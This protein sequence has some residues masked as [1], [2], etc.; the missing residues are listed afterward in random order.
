MGLD[1][2]AVTP[3]LVLAV[4]LLALGDDA[5]RAVEALVLQ[6]VENHH[7]GAWLQLDLLHLRGVLFEVGQRV[8]LCLHL[9][10]GF[11]R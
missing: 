8:V 3:H 9:L 11:L 5:A 10:E 1:V 4:V 7:V 2:V 6:D